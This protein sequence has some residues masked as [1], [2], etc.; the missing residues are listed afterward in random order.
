MSSLESALDLNRHLGTKLKRGG[1]GTYN[2]A[3]AIHNPA[4]D[5]S[6]ETSNLFA[7]GLPTPAAAE[8]LGDAT[9]RPSGFVGAALV[10]EE[11]TE[12]RDGPAAWVL[13]ANLHMPHSSNPLGT[14][15][16]EW[17]PSSRSD[18]QLGT[19]VAEPMCICTCMLGLPCCQHHTQSTVNPKVSE[20]RWL[21]VAG[22][23][24]ALQVA[25]QGRARSRV[26]SLH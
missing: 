4:G 18:P 1:E 13:S 2:T 6:L 12:V 11:P 26:H 7:G 17:C 25:H 23:R 20:E 10:L 24:L 15:Q 5:G 8:A 19:L 14:P 21:A 9:A 16:K 22:S 3:R